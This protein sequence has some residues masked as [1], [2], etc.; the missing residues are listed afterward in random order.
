M[1]NFDMKT[2]QKFNENF[3]KNIS[4]ECIK[5]FDRKRTILN[6]VKE[7]ISINENSFLAKLENGKIF[8]KGKMLHL[9][10]LDLE[11]SLVWLFGNVTEIKFLNSVKQKFSLKGWFN[12]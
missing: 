5:I 12:K 11:N 6:G 3:D 4:A 1:E 9:E 2:E 7:V 8:I 10:K